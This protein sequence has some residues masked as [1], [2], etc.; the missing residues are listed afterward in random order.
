VAERR[1]AITMP[2][3]GF[4][5]PSGRLAAWLVAP[6][7][8][9]EA[10]Q[11]VAEVETEKATVGLEA[12]AAGTVAELVAAPGDDVPVG[13]VLAWLEEPPGS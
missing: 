3:L 12:L 13:G 9:V 4:E 5:M 11:V 10:G 7:D 2:Q 8:R 6:R 1:V